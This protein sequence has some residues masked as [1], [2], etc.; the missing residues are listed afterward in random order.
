MDDKGRRK[1][2]DTKAMDE[3]TESVLLEAEI[4]ARWS[5]KPFYIS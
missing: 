4:I 1:K 5:E 2:K 3:K